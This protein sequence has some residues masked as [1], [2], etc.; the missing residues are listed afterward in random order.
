MNLA[1]RTAGNALWLLAAQIVTRASGFLVTVLLARTLGTEGFGVYAFVCA[2]VGFFA[3]L[4]DMGMDVTLIREASCDL[5]GSEGR[6]GKGIVVKACLSLLAF[7]LSVGLALALGVDGPKVLLIAIASCGLLLAPLTLYG[8]AFSATLRL[9][10]T[11]LLEIAGK[12]L[13]V[14]LLVAVLLIRP[15]LPAVFVAL[16][17]PGAAVASLN[18]FYAGRFFRPRVSF[19]WHASRRLLA[20]ALP[21]ALG[22]FCIQVLMRIDQVMIEWLRGDHE[23]GLYAGAV[24]C[25]EALHVLPA[26]LTA[27]VFP[28]LSRAARESGEAE[29]L[30]ICSLCFKYLALA[31]FPLV[32]ILFVYP[33]E[34]LSLLFGREYVP[35]ATA[36]RILSASV[37][38]VAMGY[39]LLCAAVA[40]NRLRAMV[41]LCGLL[42]TSNV[43]LNL[44]LIPGSGVSGGGNGAA[45]ATLL[46]LAGMLA[47]AH[48][49]EALRPISATFLR[50]S[51][52]PA[53]A[54]TPPLLLLA[55]R[56]FPATS[57][58]PLAAALYLLAILL[59]RGVDR[60]ELERL[61]NRP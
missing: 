30:R 20:E 29:F 39:I 45:L 7:L 1:Q 57:G 16:V 28:V 14:L 10:Y 34:I 46:S 12:I 2:Y 19:D 51:V 26:V 13:L 44:L 18:V 60:Q 6:V 47:A 24:K 33:G 9:H 54:L 23:L 36:L 53:L 49:H 55:L 38:A 37:P 52:K 4:T 56:H 58:A 8:V 50:N 48:L 15:T 32:L 5:K 35:G 21:I 41:I 22:F 17:L 42:A 11:A 43:L 61:R 40:S 27:S 25:C 3:F 59:L 31:L